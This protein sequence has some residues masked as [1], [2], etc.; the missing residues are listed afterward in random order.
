MR[1]IATGGHQK[2]SAGS[3]ARRIIL[4]VAL[5]AG[6]FGATYALVKLG[7]PIEGV[8]EANKALELGPPTRRLFYNAARVF[9]QA[10]AVEAEAEQS[11]PGSGL[12]SDAYRAKAVRYLEQALAL[13]EKERPAEF[14]QKVVGP[15]S[16]DRR[17][18]ALYP[19]RG[20]RRFAELAE[21]YAPPVGGRSQ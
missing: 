17:D 7:K 21:Q 9:A 12:R 1:N 10:S 5:A 2:K 18:G 13:L 20:S 11:S 19:L 4:L 8:R 16:R 15:D 14:W 6:A 3:L